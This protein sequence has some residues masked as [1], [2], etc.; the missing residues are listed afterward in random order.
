MSRSA[1]PLPSPLSSSCQ[2]TSSM[3]VFSQPSSFPHSLDERTPFPFRWCLVIRHLRHYGRERRASLATDSPL[4]SFFFCF[5]QPH[6]ALGGGWCPGWPQATPKGPQGL[7][8]RRSSASFPGWK[9]GPRYWQTTP[10]QT[11]TRSGIPAAAPP[12][13]FPPLSTAFRLSPHTSPPTQ[14]AGEP[15]LTVVLGTG[16]W[17]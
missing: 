6:P 10:P 1:G 13:P 3:T 8:T 15:H 12:S 2:P 9:Q 11:G 16:S 4:R 5:R 7:D 14:P 17:H